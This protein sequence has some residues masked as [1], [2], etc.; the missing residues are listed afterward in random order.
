M[1]GSDE[2]AATAAWRELGR[3][4]QRDRAPRLGHSLG[5]GPE[6]AP[7]CERIPEAAQSARRFVLDVAQGRLSLPFTSAVPALQQLARAE[8]ELILGLVRDRDHTLSM[9]AAMAVGREGVRFRQQLAD[10]AGSPELALRLAAAAG[11]AEAAAAGGPWAVE[12]LTRLLRDPSGEVRWAAAA[13]LGRAR[14]PEAVRRALHWLNWTAASR[15]T[16]VVSGAAFG[17]AALYPAARRASS[18]LLLRLAEGSPE[19]RRAAA[20]AMRGLPRRAVAKVAQRCLK[21]QHDPGVRALAAIALGHWADQGNSVARRELLRLASDHSALVRTEVARILAARPGWCDWVVIERMAGD[22]SPLVRAALA[23][24]LGERAGREHCDL[25][26][27]L[28][29]DRAA[30]VRAAAIRSQGRLGL[31]RPVHEAC[32][33]REPAVRAAAAAAL[34]PSGPA[35]TKLLLSLTHDRQREVVRAA[36]R[37]LSG[38]LL[39]L[40]GPAWARV[41]ELANDEVTALAAAEGIA[42]ALDNNP[43]AAPQVL[44]SLSRLTVKTLAQEVALTRSADLLPTRYGTAL[45]QETRHSW[46]PREATTNLLWQVAR[47]AH[48]PELADLA[49]AAA[50]VAEGGEELGGALRDLSAALSEV[51]HAKLAQVCAWLAQCAE[52]SGAQDIGRAASAAPTPLHNS[53]AYLGAAARSVARALRTPSAL[54]RSQCLARAE[55]ALEAGLALDP[56]RTDGLLVG[57]IIRRWQFIVG[58]MAESSAPAEVRLSVTSDTVLAGPETALLIELENLGKGPAYELVVQ[59]EGA[60][61]ERRLSMLPPSSKQSLSIAL[62]PTKAG[63][64]SVR[65]G[66]TYRDASGRRTGRFDGTVTALGP[67]SLRTLVNPYVV[68]KPLPP[69]SAMFFGRAAEM[70]FVE[71]ALAEEGGG[72]GVVVLVGPRRTGKTSLLRRLEQRLSRW[73]RPVFVDVQGMLVSGTEAFF[74]ELARRAMTGEEPALRDGD[75]VPYGTGAEMVREVT[76][77]LDRRVVLLLDEFDDLEEKVRSGRLGPEVFGQL[78]HLI[79]HGRNIGLVLCGTHRLEDLAGEYWSFLLNLASYQRIGTLEPTAAEELIRLPLGWMGI[80]CED[81]AVER[82]M[83]LTG[84]HPYLLQLLGYRVVELCVEAGEAAVRTSLVDAAA[85]T[86]VQQGEIHLRYLWESAGPLGQPVVHALAGQE[87]GLT[88]RELTAATR[89]GSAALARRLRALAA[90]ELV[91]EQGG[92]YRVQVGL[93]ERWLRQ[94][95][96]A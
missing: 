85:D 43:K 66:L 73:C 50:R 75:A 33:A 13:S 35:D 56:D 88:A 28:G 17:A 94:S 29:N 86:V 64:I 19:A 41:L 69:E 10:L 24:G 4:A 57:H 44:S 68:G 93:L 89:L 11:L 9:A 21:D 3:Q 48:T 80:L 77:R 67:G 26:R 6:P 52:A 91:E 83:A 31:Q 16:R 51:E 49:R 36:A 39:R 81:A 84:R 82:A 55:A 34:V 45:A 1:W 90:A 23:E 18:E 79:Q 92:R 37:T 78:R 38:H 63:R 96:A 22:S 32:T 65:V 8:P 70:A 76:D 71:R 7:E 47:A 87:A 15:D 14:G 53:A 95:L 60:G 40:R 25:L 46:Q 54:S 62:G 61:R 27:Q 42:A 72:S 59:V 58:E 2:A 20:A 30:A 12:Q 74:G 5:Y